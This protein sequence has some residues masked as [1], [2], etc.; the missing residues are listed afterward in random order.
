MHGAAADDPRYWSN[1]LE[2]TLPLSPNM[3]IY[4]LYGVG[5]ATEQ[6]YVYQTDPVRTRT[7][8]VVGGRVR[9]MCARACVAFP[10]QECSDVPFRINNTASAPHRGVRTGVLSGDGDGTVP[11][12]SLGYMCVRGWR[13]VGHAPPLRPLLVGQHVL[14]CAARDAHSRSTTPAT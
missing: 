13:L 4:C 9:L 3:R 6:G 8:L 12:L 5:K 2:T 7:A 14:T 10:P 11:L 1:A